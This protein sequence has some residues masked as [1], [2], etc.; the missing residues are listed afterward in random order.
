MRR[1]LVATFRLA[2][3]AFIMATLY[4]EIAIAEPGTTGQSLVVSPAGALAATGPKGGPF[5]P[6]TFQYHVSTTTEMVRYAVSAPAWIIVKERIGKADPNGVTVI[7]SINPLAARLQPGTYQAQI[8]FTNVTNGRGTTSRAAS[9]T[10]LS[11]SIARESTGSLKSDTGRL[12][13]ESGEL[14]LDDRG[15]P[16]LA[17]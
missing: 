5:T 14:L 7:L 9:L 13:T 16:L 4:Y 1:R 6:L 10:V 2:T 17:R 12:E 11:S 3:T 15:Q 8:A